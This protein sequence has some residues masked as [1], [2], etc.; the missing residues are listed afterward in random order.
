MCKRWI[1]LIEAE[2][3]RRGL[4]HSLNGDYVLLIWCHD[5][6]QY[7]ARTPEIAAIISEVCIEQARVA[8]EFYQTLC[9][10]AGNATIGRNW[11]ETH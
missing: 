2:L 8:G 11:S 9:P 1:L 5:E 7:G 6:V 10:T 4:V 3:E